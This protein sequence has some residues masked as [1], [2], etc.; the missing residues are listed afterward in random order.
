MANQ[1]TDE[2]LP[3]QEQCLPLGEEKRSLL[4]DVPAGNSDANET[5][6][7]RSGSAKEYIEPVR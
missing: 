2:V 7:W 4:V 1:E 5:E 3:S 6:P